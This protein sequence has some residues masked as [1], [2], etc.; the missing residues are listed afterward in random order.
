M[1][2][3]DS[4]VE[5]KSLNLLRWNTADGDSIRYNEA[6]NGDLIRGTGDF[7][8]AL[9]KHKFGWLGMIL[10]VSLGSPFWYDF[11]KTIVGL[12]Q[13]LRAKGGEVATSKPSHK[14][15]SHMT[16]ETHDRR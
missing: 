6:T 2:L 16:N 3:I 11:L 4:L 12:K 7:F 10:L 1:V 8:V 9:W 13:T 14:L 5:D 15:E